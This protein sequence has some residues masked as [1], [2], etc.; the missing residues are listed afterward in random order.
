MVSGDPIGEEP[1]TTAAYPAA[2]PLA[3]LD[4]LG[5]DD[6]T[7]DDIAD[8]PEDLR[9]ELIDGRLVLTPHGIPIHQFISKRVGDAIE[10]KC[11]EVFVLNIE[12]AVMVDPHTE[13]RP[14]VVLIREEGA[15]LSPVQA[16]DVEL[17]IEVIS[18]S[19]R[20]SDRVDKSKLYADAG[21]PAYWIF[22]PLGEA[23]TFT[24]L[25]LGPDGS[26]VQ[27]LQTDK[28]VTVDQPWEITLDLPAWTRRRDR[29]RRNA[30][31]N[32]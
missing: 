19:S 32:R 23:V 20:V 25:S 4:L 3:H 16:A 15:G 31:V 27:Q 17:V 5:R 8:L 2:S 9:Y 1:M 22:D 12:Q 10:E 13:L 29:I 30:R 11:P 14:D 21:I 24:Q 7:V 26:Y 18:K 6:L 28:L